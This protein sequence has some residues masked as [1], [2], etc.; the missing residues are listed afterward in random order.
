[1]GESNHQIPL[2]TQFV[3]WE[4]WGSHGHDTI[5]G[6][7]RN[8]GRRDALT[9]LPM[10]RQRYFRDICRIFRPFVSKTITDGKHCGKDEK[11]INDLFFYF[12]RFPTF[13]PSHDLHRCRNKQ[14]KFSVEVV[15]QA[16]PQFNFESS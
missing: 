1:M 12:A 14:L 10:P 13:F 8:A 2:A 6:E 7:L 5:E 11:C 4:I 16:D 9:N 3:V 15:V